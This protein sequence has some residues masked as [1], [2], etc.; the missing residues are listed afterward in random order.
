MAVKAVMFYRLALTVVLA[1]AVVL[2]GRVEQ[3]ILLRHLLMVVMAPL[4]THNKEGLV[5]PVLLLHLIMELVAAVGLMQALERVLM[6]HQLLVET[7][8][9]EPHQL[10]QDH[11]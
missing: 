4:Q 6:G 1:A 9:L 5:V 3:V 11:L 10:S 8:V 7:E 2:V